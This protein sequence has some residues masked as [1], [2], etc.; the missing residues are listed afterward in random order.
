MKRR[1]EYID[2]NAH[3]GN[4]VDHT[5]SI[6]AF[7]RSKL[8]YIIILGM[9]RRGKYVDLNAHAVNMVDH[10]HIV[11]FFYVQAELSGTILVISLS[12]TI[13]LIFR[14]LTNN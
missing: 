9:K 1:G 5:G 14:G 11:V 8:R 2:L 12:Q 13:W 10:T 7:D 6:V 4:M 3:A